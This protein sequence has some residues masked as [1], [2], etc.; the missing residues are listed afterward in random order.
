M[1]PNPEAFL[2]ETALKDSRLLR[3]FLDI[4]PWQDLGEEG[5]EYDRARVDLPAQV[6]AVVAEGNIRRMELHIGNKLSRGE[7]RGYE[8]DTNIRS[9]PLSSVC[10]PL[11]FRQM[12]C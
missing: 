9:P 8:Q 12:R 2:S 11:L 10:H 7:I 5:P 1:K 4:F 6:L 3:V